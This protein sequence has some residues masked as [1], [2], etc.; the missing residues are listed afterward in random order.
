VWFFVAQAPP[1][2]PLVL[3]LAGDNLAAAKSM[4]VYRVI[5][6]MHVAIIGVCGI[7]GNALLFRMIRAVTGS[8]AMARRLLLAWILVSGFVGCELSWLLS[9]YLCNPV[10]PPHIV[11]RQYFES[12]FYEYVYHAVQGR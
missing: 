9:P 7:V 4:G 12:N 2:D 5:L 1:P 11:N 6:V 3:G 8:G 10:T